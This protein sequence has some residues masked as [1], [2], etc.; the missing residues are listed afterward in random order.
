MPCRN[1]SKPETGPFLFCGKVCHDAFNASNNIPPGMPAHPPQ[2]QRQPQ[3]QQQQAI[4]QL[5]LHATNHCRNVD[6]F[7]AKLDGHPYCGRGCT[8]NGNRHKGNK[9]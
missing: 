6:C 4:P 8:P 7:N 9:W 1:C 5:P 3:P 2:Q